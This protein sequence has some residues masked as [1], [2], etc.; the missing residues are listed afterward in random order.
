MAGDRGGLRGDPI[1][2]ELCKTLKERFPSLSLEEARALWHYLHS[3]GWTF[4]SAGHVVAEVYGKGTDYRKFYMCEC[5]SKEVCSSVKS[6]IED[7]L[8]K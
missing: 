2:E 1:F 4:R 3:M 6:K 5:P 7:L 8:V